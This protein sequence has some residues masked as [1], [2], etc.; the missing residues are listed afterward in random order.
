MRAESAMIAAPASLG[1]LT[2]WNVETGAET[3]A[4]SRRQAVRWLGLL[5]AGFLAGCTPVRIGAGLYTKAYQPGLGQLDGVL[6]AFVV[7]VIPGAPADA[8]HL[9]QVFHD[10]YYGFAPVAPFFAA[11]LT[12]RA[13]RLYGE[14]SFDALPP[15]GRTGVVRSGLGADRTTR[16]LY[17]GAVLLAQA[18]FYAGIYDDD[19]G[20]ALID[21]PG[22][23]R[24]GAT[25]EAPYPQ[26]ERYLALPTTL[27]GNPG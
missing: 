27:D 6:R 26:P 10:A 8:P 9:T 17:N 2:R 13:G 1:G 19:A 7:T 24:A 4:V 3:G 15:A 14:G 20:C 21:F 22:R 12:A 18:S 23:P 16:K 25:R 11:D 5:A